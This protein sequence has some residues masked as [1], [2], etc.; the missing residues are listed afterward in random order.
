MN[1]KEISN[2]VSSLNQRCQLLGASVSYDLV[3]VTG[4]SH[5]Q[6]F[7]MEA[8]FVLGNWRL[9]ARG[10]GASKKSAKEEAARNML[11][12]ID[13]SSSFSPEANRESK[14]S[15]NPENAREQANFIAEKM[16]QLE[17]L[18]EEIMKEQSKY[19]EHRFANS[20]KKE[21]RTTLREDDHE[22]IDVSCVSHNSVGHLQELCMA[23][24]LGLPRYNELAAPLMSSAAP[25]MFSIQC[26]L[27]TEATTGDGR[28]KKEAKRIAASVMI[29]KFSG[30]N[31]FSGSA[32]QSIEKQRHSSGK[33]SPMNS[34]GE[35]TKNVLMY[36]EPDKETK[37]PSI[38][39]IMDF[40]GPSQVKK[41]KS[42]PRDEKPRD[43]WSLLQRV[44]S[45]TGATLTRVVERCKGKDC[46]CGR[47]KVQTLLQ[48][49][50]FPVIVACVCV[51]TLEKGLE[52]S[53]NA[54][55]K[56]AQTVLHYINHF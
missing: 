5:C 17:K 28:N 29:Q 3:M 47:N 53:Y 7:T 38:P 49:S 18:K 12:E 33:C 22:K 26:L 8:A 43:W 35:Q 56:L 32:N 52:D 42:S 31:D 34:Q 45:R 37:H 55:N 10:Q 44:T 40:R 23:R 20:V 6:I 24:G 2:H 16:R 25:L 50:T 14:K 15:V 1:T 36:S 41:N 9:T 4:P 21:D 54:D 11:R 51:D 46:G 30:V 27:G 13:R 48:C 19:S 39:M